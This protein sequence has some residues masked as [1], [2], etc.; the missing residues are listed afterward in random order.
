MIKKLY[1]DGCFKY[2][3]FI[4]VHQ[5]DLLLSPAACVVLIQMLKEYETNKCFSVQSLKDRMIISDSDF[6]SAV[7]NLLEREFYSIYVITEDGIGREAISLDGFFER[8]KEVLEG[9]NKV[10]YENDFFYV[11]QLIQKE[12]NRILKPEEMEVVSSLITD[13]GFKA[14]DFKDALS[15]MKEHYKVLSIRNLVTSLNRYRKEVKEEKPVPN[16]VKDF[17]SSIK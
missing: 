10:D 8:A 9:K 2:E 7:S 14:D 3:K 6:D 16:Y 11:T 12:I 15:Y 1:E 13:D 17:L 5:H 4:L